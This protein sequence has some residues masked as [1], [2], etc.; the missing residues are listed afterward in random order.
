MKL[1]NKCG[2]RVTAPPWALFLCLKEG[3]SMDDLT[4]TM[5]DSQ[6]AIAGQ[7]GNSD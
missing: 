7:Q 4:E 1:Y 5:R 6:E 2:K 3:D